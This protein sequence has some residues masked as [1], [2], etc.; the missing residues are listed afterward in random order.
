MHPT[1]DEMSF[2]GILP[3]RP[4]AACLAVALAAAMAALPVMGAGE[5]PLGMVIQA[6]DSHLG[7]ALAAAGAN[8]YPGDGL[9]TDPGGTLRLKVG[10]GQIYMLSESEVRLAQA[11][12]AVQ[13]IV[14]RGVVGFSASSSGGMELQTPEGV[15]RAANGKSAYGQVALTSP[16]EMTVTSFNGDLVLDYYGDVHP[17]PSGSSYSVSLEPGPGPQPTPQ[18]P[19]GSG[20]PSHAINTHIV[21]RIIAVA[22]LAGVAFVLYKQICESPSKV[23]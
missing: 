19:A 6:Q 14:N 3:K 20:A 17:I 7:G 18:G 22:A 15:L 10:S 4:A 13:A 2:R 12:G 11:N 21:T 23:N 9:S 1:V 16:T 8:V 5:Q